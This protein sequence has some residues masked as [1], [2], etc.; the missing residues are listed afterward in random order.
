MNH[1]E[2]GM[3]V[4]EI[5][6]SSCR[7]AFAV[8]Q[9]TTW[10]KTAPNQG[11]VNLSFNNSPTYPNNENKVYYDDVINGPSYINSL[12][13]RNGVYQSLR[14]DP[15]NSKRHSGYKPTRENGLMLVILLM[16]LLSLILVALVVAGVLGPSCSCT[17]KGKLSVMHN[18]VSFDFFKSRIAQ[19]D[20]KT[21]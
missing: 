14:K 17:S 6:K 18:R 7:K 19:G 8:G 3:E 10:N 1:I 20:W 9:E 2:R 16:S 5:P 12:Q 15:Q 13:D 21:I 4:R 11:M